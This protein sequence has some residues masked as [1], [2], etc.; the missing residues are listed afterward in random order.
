MRQQLR[1]MD[2]QYSVNRLDLE[3][4]FVGNDDIRS[5]A[6]V[7]EQPIIFYRQFDLA[8]VRYGMAIQFVT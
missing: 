8:R 3:D 6:T 1:F 7:E 2:R 4:D 5:I